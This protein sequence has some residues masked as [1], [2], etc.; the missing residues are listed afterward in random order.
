MCM[1]C[2]KLFPL[3]PK[4]STS[5][6]PGHK[7][8]RIQPL[9][10]ERLLRERTERRK[11]T[12]DLVKRQM[13]KEGNGLRIRGRWIA[14]SEL[15]FNPLFC[16]LFLP[17]ICPRPNMSPSITYVLPRLAPILDFLTPSYTCII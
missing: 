13:L 15:Q 6:L 4:P 2:P 1:D 17:V 14:E 8:R 11:K 12:R 10:T 5:P 3:A 16:L 9:T 7:K